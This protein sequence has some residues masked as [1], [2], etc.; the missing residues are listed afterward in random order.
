MRQ[1]GMTRLDVTA[2]RGLLALRHDLRHVLA[3]HTVG[4]PV[5]LL[6]ENSVQG[7]AL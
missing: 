2:T 5:I 3:E 4:G 7:T 1:F 6:S